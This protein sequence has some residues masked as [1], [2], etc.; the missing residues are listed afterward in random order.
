MDILEIGTQLIQEKFGIDLEGGV[1]AD[2]LT[3]LLGGEG[4]AIDIQELI[5]RFTAGGGI[6]DI[7]GSWLG[8]GG[9]SSISVEQI[10]NIL[11]GDNIAN[12]ASQLGIDTSGAAEGLTE[13]I[14]QMIDK[15]SS[16]GSLLDN[17]G[18]AEGVL[19][20][21]KKFF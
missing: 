7:V 1:I 14:P 10:Q 4:G 17:L 3:S 20:L 5:S 12:F 15:V 9:N 16:G 2:A 11:G 8:D 6:E 13:V 21:A 19:G 18:G